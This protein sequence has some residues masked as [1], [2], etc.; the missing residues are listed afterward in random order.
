MKSLPSSAFELALT[1]VF[2]PEFVREV[3]DRKMMNESVPSGKLLRSSTLLTLVRKKVF[4]L[5]TK[6]GS[7]RLADLALLSPSELRDTAK[8]GKR[9]IRWLEDYLQLLGVVL[10]ETRSV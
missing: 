4:A 6:K 8:F 1:E 10:P 5:S 7:G 3:L 2:D 9:T